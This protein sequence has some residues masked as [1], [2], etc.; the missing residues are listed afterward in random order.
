MLELLIAIALLIEFFILIMILKLQKKINKYESG[1]QKKIN[2]YESVYNIFINQLDS[3]AR[4]I[5]E[6]FNDV[7]KF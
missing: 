2:K 5:A 1:L 4:E 7:K 3:K 6:D